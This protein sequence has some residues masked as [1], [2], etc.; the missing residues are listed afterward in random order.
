MKLL[1]TLLALLVTLTSGEAWACQLYR[2]VL[3]DKNG[4]VIAGVTVT[5]V[6][7]GTTTVV[8]L[9]GDPLCTITVANPISSASDGSFSFYVPDGEIGLN[10][11]KSGLTFA[12]IPQVA[13]YDPLGEN[14]KTVAFYQTTDLCA[15]GIG[16]I[17]QIGT[18]PMTLVINK[19]VTCSIT[20][21]LPQTLVVRC[22]G[23]G[24][25]NVASGQTLTVVGYIY[26]CKTSGVSPMWQGSGSVVLLSGAGPNPWGFDGIRTSTHA[27]PVSI[28]TKKGETFEITAATNAIFTISNPDGPSFGRIIRIVIINTSGGAMGVITWDTQY[29]LAGAFTNPATG[30]RRTITFYTDGTSGNWYELSRTAADVPN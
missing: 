6:T 30:N 24:S 2:D 12:N 8:T 5:V 28:Q 13:M 14:I 4:N 23:L 15:A 17:D 19:P 11:V 22:E 18:T 3:L 9:Y 27:T 7:A 1:M 26:P 21:T 16:A 29:K 25:V 10:F 20:K